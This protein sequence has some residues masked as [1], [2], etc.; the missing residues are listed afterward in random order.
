[1]A[2][3]QTLFLIDLRKYRIDVLLNG[4]YTAP[5]LCPI[6]MAT[7]FYD[8]HYKHFGKQH[9]TKIELFL[10]SLIYPASA[11]RSQAVITMTEAVARELRQFYPWTRKRIFIVPH[12]ADERL[13][14]VKRLRTED[15]KRATPPFLLASSS[16]MAHKNFGR[17]LQ[18]FAKFRAEQRDTRL[19]VT[20]LKSRDAARLDQMRSELNLQEHVDFTGWISEERLL[21]LFASATMFV[22][23]SLHE[24]FGIPVLEAM[25]AGIPLACSRIAPLEE[26]AGDCAEYFDPLDVHDIARALS[27]VYTDRN[28]QQ[29]LAAAGPIRAQA[30]HLPENTSKLLAVLRSLFRQE[31]RRFR[32]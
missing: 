9:A 14:H 31:S 4:S 22:H 30:F 28:L 27:A 25:T 12:S 24:G 32:R 3:E 17:L 13:E 2:Y 21:S 10:A 20:G 11:F 19:V 7:V 26:I 29:R 16:L 15:P 23:A 18:A 5:L 6:P 8:F 1:V